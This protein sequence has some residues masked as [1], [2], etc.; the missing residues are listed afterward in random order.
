MTLRKL[1]K[2]C[3]LPSHSQ[4]CPRCYLSPAV[5]H[6]PE[7]ADVVKFTG[8]I[9]AP[10]HLE[11][12]GRLQVA[13]LQQHQGQV[14]DEQQRVHQRG[15]VLH[16]APV[17]PLPGLQH[18]HA[19]EEPVGGH[20]QEDQHHQQAAEDVEAGQGGAGGSQEQRPGRDEQHQQLEGQRDVKTLAGRP[21]RLQRVAPQH[22]REHQEGQ[23]R[24]QG[25]EAQAAAQRQAQEA[26]ALQRG[27]LLQVFGDTCQV[28]VGDAVLRGAGDHGGGLAPVVI[29][30]EE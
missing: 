22:L 6:S 24:Q 28:L 15:G 30:Q 29:L 1:G 5:S 11:A 2:R 4:D 7:V 23:R 17:V 16:D 10:H 26:P 25:E 18:T 14:L 3:T 20:K 21:A 13:D 19:V 12:E 9:C 8:S 27:G